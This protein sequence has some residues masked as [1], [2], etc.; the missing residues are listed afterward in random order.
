MRVC[1]LI[2]DIAARRVCSVGNC[3]CAM[4]VCTLIEGYS[5]MACMLWRL[6]LAV[7]I[8]QFLGVAALVT[9]CQKWLLSN[10]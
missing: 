5:R 8:S 3:A 7:V 1:T 10:C 6:Y 4:R 9:W 2:E